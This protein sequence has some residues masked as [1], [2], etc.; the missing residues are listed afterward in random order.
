MAWLQVLKQLKP[1]RN[2]FNASKWK[3]T[4]A[5]TL[6]RCKLAISRRGELTPWFLS[7]LC[8]SSDVFHKAPNLAEGAVARFGSFVRKGAIF[9]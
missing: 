4:E 9:L 8:D 3:D 1:K 6:E 5:A 2:M 7:Q